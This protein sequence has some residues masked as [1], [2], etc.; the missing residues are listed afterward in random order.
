MSTWDRHHYGFAQHAATKSKDTT[1]V[2][3]VLVSPDGADLLTGFNGPPRGVRD[4]VAERWLRPTKYLYV[5]HA[6]ENLI[7]FAARHGIRTEGCTV[8]VT[9]LPCAR[10]SRALIQ[11]GIKAVVYGDGT[12]SMPDEEFKAAREMLCEA[13]VEVRA[14]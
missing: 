1:I 12:T 14:L 6:E 10:C 3:A 4:D 8:Y 7:S 5:S 9:H 11:A 13:G 2:G